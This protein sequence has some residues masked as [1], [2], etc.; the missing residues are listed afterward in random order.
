MQPSP[1]PGKPK[2]VG[3]AVLSVP[4]PSPVRRC[5][6]LELPQRKLHRLKTWDYSQNGYYYVTVCTMHRRNILCTI[7]QQGFDTIVEPTAVGNLVLDAWDGL[8]RISPHIKTD[9]FCLM[10][11]HIHGII[12]IDAPE[13]AQV[14]GLD[15]LM[16]GFKSV[17]SRA[18][19]KLVSP[20]H[21]NTLW[22]SSYYD[23]IIRNEAMLLEKRSYI[24]GNPSKWLED[25]L[26]PDN[27][28]NAENSQTE[29]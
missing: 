11:N 9:Y 28:L 4:R 27:F 21:K 23:E 12:V 13:G 24:F 3:N 26:H 25:S 16:H 20:E 2:T 15:K 10:P 1:W 22:Q 19:N 7:R 17:A 6:F 8:S 5:L 14:P 18:Y 29:R